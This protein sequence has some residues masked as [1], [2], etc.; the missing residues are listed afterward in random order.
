MKILVSGGTG[1]IGRN[2]IAKISQNNEVSVIVREK[3]DISKLEKKVKIFVYHEYEEIYDIMKEFQPDL[4]INLAAY[5]VTEHSNGE[6]IQKLIESNIKYPTFL[7]DAM[8][9][10]HVKYLINTST[11]W[12][13]Y[14]EKKYC[15]VNLYAATKQCFE[16]VIEFYHDNNE[17]SAISLVLYDTYGYNDERKKIINLFSKI[18]NSNDS[19]DMSPGSQL[20]DLIY[21]EDIVN[22]YELAINK[23]IHSKCINKKYHIRS[24]NPL[25][26]KEVAET[27]SKVMDVKLN[28]NWGKRA[29]RDREVMKTYQKGVVL[30]GWKPKFNLVNGLTDIRRRNNE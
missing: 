8:A 12:Q 19:L 30:P 6:D 4:V 21:I 5:Y 28:I 16:D 20:I 10:C 17:I 7:L 25:S 23:L 1:Y 29:Y 9:K 24:N 27:Y 13:N 26:L 2:I 14:H 22:A 15:P 11:S 18:A 3:S